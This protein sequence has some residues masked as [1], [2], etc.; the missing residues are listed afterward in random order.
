MIRWRTDERKTEGEAVRTWNPWWCPLGEAD[1]RPAPP[2]PKPTMTRREAAMARTRE[3][4]FGPAP[5]EK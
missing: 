3:G 4:L 2:A 5:W 1:P